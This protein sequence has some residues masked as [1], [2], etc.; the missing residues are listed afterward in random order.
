MLHD[1]QGAL[2][3]L[4]KADVLQPNKACILKIR[5][6]VKRFLKDYQGALEDLDKADV[7]EPNN[8]STLGI[9]GNVKSKLND[10]QG[11][12][13]DLDKADV[14]EPNNAFT[15]RSRGNVKYKLHDYRGA[16]E[17]LDKADVL[18]PNNAPTLK[19]RGNVKYKLDDYQGALE[20]FDRANVLEP[21]N[22]F[23]LMSCA[24]IKWK[25]DDYQG[26]LEDL[27]KVDALE[28]NIHLILQTQ[29]C[30][31]WMLNE[32]EPIVKLLPFNSNIQSFTYNELTIGKKLGEGAFGKVYQSCW[33]DTK[34]AIKVLKRNGSLNEGAKKSFVSEVRTLGSIQ[35]INLVH[36]LGYCIEGLKHML[37]YEYISNSSLDTW[38]KKD[39]LL[40]WDRRVCIIIG[41]AQGLAHL[42][43]CNPI[44]LHLDIKPQNILLDQDYTP[45]LADFGLAKILDGKDEDVIQLASKSTPGTLGY[46]A[47]EILEKKQASTKS[48]VYSFGVLLI[49]LLNGSPFILDG[50]E[51]YLHKFIQ[52]AQNV[53]MKKNGFQQIFNVV[54]HNSIIGFNHNE[55]KSFLQISLQCIKKDPN[56]RPGIQEVLQLFEGLD[57]KKDIQYIPTSIQVYFDILL[58]RFGPT[59]K[60]M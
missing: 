5:G 12:L 31:K 23:N 28:R 46:M 21:N 37:V 55:A 34:I 33:K 42:H 32:Y 14:L 45:K 11:A 36:L 16:L 54:I 50:N 1:Y 57:K 30:L 49:Q 51:V 59:F 25:L 15:L 3:D 17:E 29:K 20:D 13:E 39:N 6:D 7:F 47:P 56:Q 8:A 4:D 24:R 10:D 41:V 27:D 44:I 18:Q 35:H 53:H 60:R 19:S 48:D 58:K 43:K 2:E 22:A 40:D 52:W 26:A 9:R 38:L